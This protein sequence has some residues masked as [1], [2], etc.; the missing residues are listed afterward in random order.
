MEENA[1]QVNCA[2]SERKKLQEPELE[3]LTPFHLTKWCPSPL[4]G[5]EKKLFCLKN[6]KQ[7][8]RLW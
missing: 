4:N 8:N 1:K 6:S 7:Y 3:K 5:L 2:L